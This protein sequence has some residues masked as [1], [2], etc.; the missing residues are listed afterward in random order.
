VRVKISNPRKS[1]EHDLREIRIAIPIH[2]SRYAVTAPVEYD[3]RV[4]N[5]GFQRRTAPLEAPP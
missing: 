4:R 3:R 2:E 1:T 5:A